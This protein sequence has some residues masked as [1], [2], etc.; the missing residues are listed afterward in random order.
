MSPVT[1]I[2]KVFIVVAKE[3]T[4]YIYEIDIFAEFH[5][6]NIATANHQVIQ[7]DVHISS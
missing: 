1:Q 6:G 4:Q 7:T 2:Y 5:K 3:V